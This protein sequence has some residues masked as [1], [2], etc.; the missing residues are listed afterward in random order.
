MRST[1]NEKP[2]TL[3]KVLDGFDQSKFNWTGEY[4]VLED[5][6]LFGTMFVGDASG[7]SRCNRVDAVKGETLYIRDSGNSFKGHWVTFIKLE[8]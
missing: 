4:T 6:T 7:A 2:D 8:K 1:Y 3:A 5:C